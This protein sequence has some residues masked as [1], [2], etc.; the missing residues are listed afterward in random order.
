MSVARMCPVPVGEFVALSLPCD[1]GLEG[2]LCNV[3]DKI[4]GTVPMASRHQRI[5][6]PQANRGQLLKILA[7]HEIEKN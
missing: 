4:V 2:T 7:L 5:R 3:P 1:A 6:F